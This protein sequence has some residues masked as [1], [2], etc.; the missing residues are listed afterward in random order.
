MLLPVLVFKKMKKFILLIF[1]VFL[2]LFLSSDEVF[3]NS[4]YDQSSLDSFNLL[5][6]GFDGFTLSNIEDNFVIEKISFRVQF[7]QNVS[8]TTIENQCPT[9]DQ[10]LGFQIN[11]GDTA[12][13]SRFYHNPVA[14]SSEKIIDFDT[15]FLNI[16]GS[17]LPS[18]I[19][20]IG[21]SVQN[22]FFCGNSNFG[23]QMGSA[24]V[25]SNYVSHWLNDNTNT[26]EIYFNGNANSKTPV[27]IV[28]GVLGTEIF[29]GDEELWA[30][31]K[32]AI[33]IGDDDFMDPMQFNANLT[34]SD[35][36]VY[37]REVIKQRPFFNYTEDLI[38]EF[39][40]QGYTENED[41]FTFP[42]DWRYGV[43]QA[44]ID[45][46]KAKIDEIRNGGE[47]DIIA[48]S[49]GGLLV[50]KYVIDNPG[51]HH[52]GKA[53][54]L[55]VP[56]TGAPK[57]VKTML[58]GDNFNVHGL[59][60]AEMKKIAQNLPVVYDLAPSQEYFDSKGSYFKTIKQKF[61]AKDEVKDLTHQ[62]T[63]DL[64]IN[65][66]GMNQAAYNNAG[67]LH[68]ESFK[69]FDLRTQGVDLYNIVGCKSGTI[70][71]VV[72]K[73]KGQDLFGH[74]IL[75]YLEP[76]ETPGDGTVPL[77]SATNLPVDQNKKFYAL[78]A[79]HGK[80]PSQNGIRQQIVNI[81]VGT[82]LDTQGKLTQD[83]NNCKLKG[84]AVSIY[85][86]LD[87]EALDQNGNR[88][89]IAEDGSLQN[90]IPGADFNVFGD[91]KF[92]YMP[93]DAGETYKI[94]LKGTGSGS[95]TLGIKDID[96]N[97][98]TQSQNFINL[99]VSST[100]L[101]TLEFADNQAQLL[102][103]NDGNGTV[104]QTLAPTSVLDANQS[105]DL[106]SPETTATV[107]GI[108]GNNG[109]YKSDAQVSLTAL[110]D[111]S[112]ML[113]TLYS[114]DNQ[115][116]LSYQSPISLISEG[117]HTIKYYSVD[118]AGNNEAVQILE[119]K[120]DKQAPEFTVWFDF[121]SQSFKFSAQDNL[122]S[123]PQI[124]CTSIDCQGSDQAGNTAALNF[125]Q[126]KISNLY[127]LNLSKISYNGVGT[128]FVENLF[129]VG[130]SGKNLQNSAQ[131]VLI[132]KQQVAAIGFTRDKNESKIVELQSGGS[133]KT[134]VLSGLHLIKLKTNN[135][136]LS[137]KVE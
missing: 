56:N 111:N 13:L 121:A 2:G 50:K 136:N 29:K 89:G 132:K 74:P 68:T 33:P 76:E 81:I 83:I 114:L 40:S 70:G 128:N 34:P 44:N 1:F 22:G 31:P 57:A 130:L 119:I 120:I 18:L 127:S 115:P 45:A 49:T 123:N 79:N 82:N 15:A 102:L 117:P 92:V 37:F 91:H 73:Y 51:N 116:Y 64:L 38:Q 47:V 19:F 4:P 137:A 87:I 6:Q 55:G 28:P 100:T 36:A 125:K 129:T 8:T 103:D 3:A 60:A 109:W 63:L 75:E 43:N 86:P 65:G 66:R 26:P 53:V 7:I 98:V 61:L 97:Q 42:Y 48:H 71:K 16:T 23:A 77:E 108:V 12:I 94:N 85:S 52:L 62:E 25:T 112:G 126:T 20:Y 30:N 101:G 95:F 124:N 80:M 118:N 27:L 24:N 133:L 35:P 134:Y 67:N 46:L 59:S 135:Q 104:D 41:L 11:Q 107:S 105:L 99:P 110:D 58:A 9:L 21:H 93:E 14:D 69:N 88:L 5:S 17:D 122:D 32:M 78:D 72:E 10:S 39:T 54:F 131:A 113:E 90:D 84:K 96:A 106:I